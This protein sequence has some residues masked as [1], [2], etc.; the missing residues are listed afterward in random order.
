MDFINRVTKTIRR[1]VQAN[2]IGIKYTRASEWKLPS[3]IF[4]NNTKVDLIGPNDI[5]TKIAFLDIF[6]DD[7]YGL[8]KISKSDVKI[9]LDIGGHVGFFSL[10][11]RSIFPEALIHCYEPNPR[12]KTFIENQST[13]GKFKVFMEA[14]GLS[15][16]RIS[17]ESNEDSVQTISKVNEMGTIPLTSFK[18][19]LKRLNGK[20]DLLKLDCEG[21]EWGIFK[22]DLHVWQDIKHICMEYHLTEKHTREEVITILLNLGY[23]ITKHELS[24]STWG[25]IHAKRK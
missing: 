7:C 3:H 10:Y 1:K 25:I 6:L 4:L 21:A 12:L 13:I 15:S 17:L 16:G 20:V 2:K 23:K 18:D 19:C 5:G 11:A 22:E 8:K 9:I 24:G 14:V